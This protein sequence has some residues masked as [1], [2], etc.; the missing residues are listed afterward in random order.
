[1]ARNLFDEKNKQRLSRVFAYDSNGNVKLETLH[2]KF[3]S[4]DT[5]D[6]LETTYT[7]SHDGL[8]LKTSECDP[9]G[10]YTYFDYYKGSN[11]LKSKFICDGDKIKKREFYD[12]D[13]NAI[14]IEEIIDDGTTKDKHDLN[15]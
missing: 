6:K 9:L 5:S 1:I 14:L 2:G 15:D 4:A 8:N 13:K 7:Y 3:T 12:Y 11:L 10:N